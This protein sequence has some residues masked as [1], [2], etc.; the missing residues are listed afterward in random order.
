MMATYSV[1]SGSRLQD[2]IKKILTTKELQS[3]VNLLMAWFHSGEIHISYYH[4]IL[5][6]DILRDARIRV[7]NDDSGLK[8]I[9]AYLLLS[10]AEEIMNA[11]IDSFSYEMNQKVN[12][13]VYIAVQESLEDLDLLNSQLFA[14]S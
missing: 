9:A 2:Q 5:I 1:A 6:C 13:L 3:V 11:S 10:K 12:D 7:T 8:Y 4:F 14:S